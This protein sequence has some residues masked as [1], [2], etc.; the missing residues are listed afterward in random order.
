[1]VVMLLVCVRFLFSFAAAFI[2]QR[3]GASWQAWC[4][5]RWDTNF[6]FSLFF[7]AWLER[8]P[9]IPPGLRMFGFR[10]RCDRQRFGGKKG[11]SR[12]RRSL[13]VRFSLS[14]PLP[15]PPQLE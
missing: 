7:S 15:T 14:E 12:S 6:F 9:A 2:S 1:M 10:G 4:P 5:I 8:V 11:T 13:L 3:R